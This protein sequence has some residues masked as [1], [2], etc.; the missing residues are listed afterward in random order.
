M[1][2]QL[3]V[4]LSVIILEFTQAQTIRK[5]MVEPD[6]SFKVDTSVKDMS[7]YIKNLET[8]LPDGNR[9][10][11]RAIDLKRI[12]EDKY[13]RKKVN[14]NTSGS[15]SGIQGKLSIGY[16]LGANPYNFSV[17]SDNALCIS[18]SGIAVS[19][20]NTSYYFFNT[21]DS[22]TLANG[23]LDSYTNDPNATV[24][25]P[26]VIYDP[27]QDRFIMVMLKDFS[28]V[29]SNQVLVAFS[30]TNNPLD[31]WHTYALNGNPFDTT[32][33][34]DYP[35]I[36]ITDDELFITGNLLGDGLPW[37]TGFKQTVVWQIDK[38]DGYTNQPLDINLWSDIKFD[39]TNFIRNLHPIRNYNNYISMDS[40]THTPI[41]SQY[42]LSNRNFAEES[43]TIFLVEITGDMN[44]TPSMNIT[45]LHS[46]NN[47]YFPINGR[48]KNTIQQL[49]TNDSRVLGATYNRNTDLIQFVQHTTDTTTGNVAIYHGFIENASTS[50]ICTS[51]LIGDSIRDYGYPNMASTA[52]DA[53]DNSTIICFNYTSSDDN[54]GHIA[55]QYD[56]AGVYSEPLILKTGTNRINVL[57]GN[58]ERW[59]DY[60]GIQ[61]KYNDPGKVWFEGIY[62]APQE[63]YG[64][65]ISEIYDANHLLIPLPEPPVTDGISGKKNNISK[66]FPNPA[67]DIFWF[68]FEM[69]RTDN[70][71]ID[72]YDIR[73]RKIANLYNGNVKQGL[74]MISLNTSFLSKGTYSLILKNSENNIISTNKLVVN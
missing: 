49:A 37:Q 2:I 20:I 53:Y 11:Q 66:V 7:I 48:Q 57:S 71:I 13:P 44:S 61:R 54:P 4:L 56:T 60:S 10:K 35:A 19:C 41:S 73:G 24:Y 39:S 30:S 67:R 70:V 1:K 23:N 38:N 74:N 6:V 69:N 40:S 26:K 17:P 55:V 45:L 3:T 9:D 50:P 5:I 21:N 52:L 12:I 33:W 22:T 8:P 59:G 64:N 32:Q 68:N 14:K 51:Q 72:I 62:G 58:I 65:W 47:Y 43:D 16:S 27:K 36:S 46:N 28:S 63:R 15:K 31:T 29:D 18:D 25:D 34:T 42:F